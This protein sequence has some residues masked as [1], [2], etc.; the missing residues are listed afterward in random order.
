MEDAIQSS[1][2]VSSPD[3]A[4]WLTK[5]GFHV[6][7]DYVSIKIKF[8]NLFF[9]WNFY[10]SGGNYGRNDGLRFTELKSC[11][12]QRNPAQTMLAEKA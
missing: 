12:C 2:Y 10:Y 4:G 3:F 9:L 11:T 7:V 8:S 5:R 1:V 6:S